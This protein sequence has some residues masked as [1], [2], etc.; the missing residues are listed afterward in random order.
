MYPCLTSIDQNSYGL[1]KVC[2]AKKGASAWRVTL[3]RDGAKI[4]EKEFPFLR[5]GGEEQAL[6]VAEAFRNEA[7]LLYP[8]AE[9]AQTRQ[10]KR[11]SNTSGYPGVSKQTMGRYTYWVAQ[12]KTREGR[13]LCNAYR[14]EL[15]GDERALKMALEAREKQLKSIQHRIFRSASGERLYK[16]LSAPSD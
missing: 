7:V 2:H 8:P 9:S 3:Y 13:K 15:Y 5:H 16:E 6:R 11:K 1:T 10:R 12:T 4:I 14:I